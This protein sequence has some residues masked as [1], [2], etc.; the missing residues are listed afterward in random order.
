MRSEPSGLAARNR[1]I[2][3]AADKVH[4]HKGRSLEQYALINKQEVDNLALSLT[5]ASKRGK[6][7]PRQEASL[8]PID[9]R[10]RKK[11]T[12]YTR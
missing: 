12:S 5:L 1:C 4:Y 10:S 6:Q 11:D 7:A 9:Q 2:K 8:K 3:V